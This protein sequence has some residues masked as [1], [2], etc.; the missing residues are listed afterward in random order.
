MPCSQS[1][2]LSSIH[3]LLDLFLDLFP[4]PAHVTLE[5]LSSRVAGLILTIHHHRLTVFTWEAQVQHR[6]RSAAPHN[7][8]TRWPVRC[9]IAAIKSDR[10]PRTLNERS[11]CP[12]RD[13]TTR[14]ES[15]GD[16]ISGSPDSAQARTRV[17]GRRLHSLY[18][19]SVTEKGSTALTQV[20]LLFQSSLC[21]GHH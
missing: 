12:R 16:H 4:T 10:C 7:G 20:S 17:P 19:S 6:T 18:S 9:R 5:R 2:P 11:S 3:L 8:R 13:T 1:H 15:K 14:S 21:A